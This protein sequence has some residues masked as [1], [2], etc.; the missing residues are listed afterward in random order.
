MIWNS[1]YSALNL[2]NSYAMLIDS[3]GQIIAHHGPE[4][5]FKSFATAYPATAA[6]LTLAH[7]TALG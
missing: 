7:Q 4:L 2:P 6:G 5:I 3:Q 1:T